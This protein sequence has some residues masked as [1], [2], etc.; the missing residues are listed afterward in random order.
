MIRINLLASERAQA[1]KKVPF[2]AG[3][4]LTV[5]STAESGQPRRGLRHHAAS[6]PVPNSFVRRV[7]LV[8]SSAVRL[9][10]VEVDVPWS[11][12]ARLEA[13]SYCQRQ[14]S[15]LSGLSRDHVRAFAI[16]RTYSHYFCGPSYA[17]IMKRPIGI[18]RLM[19]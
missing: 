5:D 3:Q 11:R 8:R 6:L 4:K 14:I 15:A 18:R 19:T 12:S 17:Q 9:L 10:R 2:Q 7:V 13:R 16:C 1:K